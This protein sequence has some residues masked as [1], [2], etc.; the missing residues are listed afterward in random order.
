MENRLVPREDTEIKT[1]LVFM[2]RELPCTV[3]NLSRGGA[4]LAIDGEGTSFFSMNDI[5][6]EVTLIKENSPQTRVQARIIRIENCGDILLV[7][8]FFI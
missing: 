2:D 5:G 3:K 1:S 7:A 6:N 4:L 8:L